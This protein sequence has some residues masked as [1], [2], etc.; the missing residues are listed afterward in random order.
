MKIA[1]RCHACLQ[2]LAR[3]TVS[4]SGADGILLERCFELIDDFYSPDLNPTDI[5]SR[6]LKFIRKESGVADPFSAKKEVEWKEATNA[7]RE[8]RN[9]FGTDLE[10]LLKY[11]CIGN[12]HDYFGGAYNISD[13]RF[14]GDIEGIRTTIMRTGGNV[15]FFADNVGDF[16]FDLPL[17]RHLESIGRRVYYAVKE[18]PAQ[19]DL[20]MPDV[21]R[22]GLRG[23]F[24]NI[25]SSGSDEV[26]MRKEQMAHD[27]RELWESDALVIAKGMAN[28]ETISE[29]H[30]DRHVVYIL[31]VKCRTVAEALDRAVG[32]HTSFTGGAYGS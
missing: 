29:F 23:M 20:S 32:E 3:R 21:E 9:F 8:L 17:I 25:I 1:E 14:A 26:G 31:K 13:F 10:G 2:D 7:A 19:N 28:Y 11:S 22:L 24:A 27:V 12:S 18:S 16:L 4:L 5:S 15:L 6:L 30:D